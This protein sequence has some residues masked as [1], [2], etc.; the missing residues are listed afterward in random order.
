MTN[1]RDH[2][3][4]QLKGYDVVELR[5][6]AECLAII[7]PARCPNVDGTMRLIAAHSRAQ[8]SVDVVHY[9]ETMGWCT[10]RYYDYN[11]ELAYKVTLSSYG[12]MEYIRAIRG[13]LVLL[14]EVAESAEAIAYH[15][16]HIGE[17]MAKVKASVTTEGNIEHTYEVIVGNVGSVYNGKD[18]PSAIAAFETWV[19]NSRNGGRAS[20][21]PVTLM[22]DGEPTREYEPEVT[23]GGNEKTY[24]ENVAEFN[25]AREE[26]RK[27]D[28]EP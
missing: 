20:N 13:R 3:D 23:T 25:A 22:T 26:D 12:V 4:V 11:M 6:V 2:E 19:Y 27:K 5:R 18:E 24:E 21:E 9:V 7:N 17:L 1:E 28:L 8:L 10:C 15:T 14:D 16:P